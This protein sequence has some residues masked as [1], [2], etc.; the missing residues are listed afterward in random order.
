MKNRISSLIFIICIVALSLS[1]CSKNDTIDYSDSNNWAFYVDKPEH[2]VDIF[3]IAP[4]SGYEDSYNMRMDDEGYKAS[5][6]GATAMEKGIY[7]TKADFY[8]PFYRQVSLECYDLPEKEREQ[9]L[10]K[11][12][13]DIDEAFCYY[14]ENINNG[15]PYILAGFSQGGD[16][17]KRLLKENKYIDENMVAAYAIG[18]NFTADEIEKYDNI[19]MAKGENDTGVVISFCSEAVNYNGYNIIAPTKTVGINPLNWKTDSTKALKDENF[20][21]CFTNYSGVI[22]KDIPQLTGAYLD[23]ERGTLKVTDVTSDEY[24][25][26]LSFLEDGNFHLYDYLFFYRNLQKN[27]E[28]RIE[29]FL[30]SK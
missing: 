4:T 13:D 27:V 8:A 22:L 7:D 9:Y 11:A 5:F 12:Y 21:A 20:G 1:G 15:R 24:P 6:V 10:E 16:M 25:A 2:D 28:V 19:N 3:F 23:S 18:W 14:M 26:G 30:S 17:V 29:A